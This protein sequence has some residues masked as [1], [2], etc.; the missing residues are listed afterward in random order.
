MSHTERDEL[1]ATIIE[2]GRDLK[3]AGVSVMGDGY[4]GD[5]TRA[6]HTLQ[7]TSGELREQADDLARQVRGEDT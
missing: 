2:A 6:V 1:R 4:D 5:L 3:D 7:C